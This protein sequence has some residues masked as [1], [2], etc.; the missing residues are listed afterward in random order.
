FLFPF[1]IQT[2]TRRLLRLLPVS[3]LKG[4]AAARGMLSAEWH[5]APLR[6]AAVPLQ[7]LNHRVRGWRRGIHAFSLHRPHVPGEHAFQFQ[8]SPVHVRQ[9]LIFPLSFISRLLV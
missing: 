2:V 7:A 5:A 9:S 3:F 6:P 8:Q 1:K 4:P